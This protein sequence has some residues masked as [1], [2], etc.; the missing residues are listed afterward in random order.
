MFD[1]GVGGLTVLWSLHDFLPAEE[2]IYYADQAHFPYGVRS[3]AEVRR[4][5]FEAAEALCAW[6]AKLIVLACNTATSAALPEL[7]AHLS[8]PI[9][10]IEPAIKPACA[11]TRNGRIGVLAT[12]GTVGGERLETLIGRVAGAVQ[13]V[14]VAAGGLVESIE[15][16]GSGV[17]EA[18]LAEALA[19]LREAD[20]DVVVLGCTHYAFLKDRVAAA[21]GETVT[22]LEPAA[23]VARQVARVLSARGLAAPD[24]HVGTLRYH[25]SATDGRLERAVVRLRP[26]FECALAV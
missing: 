4:F 23:A 16:D 10:G 3:P 19:P 5:V 2:L 15:R 13:I 17:V 12:S 21:M 25:S 24:R 14:R 20:V 9:V 1:S 11:L 18:Q 6:G 8:I 7:R 22:V 26:R